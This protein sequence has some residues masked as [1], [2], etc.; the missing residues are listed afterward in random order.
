KCFDTS[1]CVL[2]DQC[3]L[4][5]P[6]AASE[7]TKRYSKPL[8]IAKCACHHA[9]VRRARSPPMPAAASLR[10]AWPAA[11][12]PFDDR[13]A[14]DLRRLVRHCQALLQAG[15]RGISLFGTTGE[16]TALS[17]DE[18][19]AALEAV[20]RGGVPADRLLPAVGCCDVPTTLA[21]S[22]HAA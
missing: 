3:F 19:M 10:G 4:A 6:C 22:V 21:L 1:C 17:A 12:T 5:L 2:P 8:P 18:R 7:A 16:G 20:I 14:I 15:C 11:L 9:R 13:L